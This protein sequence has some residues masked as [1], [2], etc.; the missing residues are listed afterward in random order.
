MKY[1][2]ALIILIVLTGCQQRTLNYA[3]IGSLQCE[4]DG[5]VGIKLVG[6]S[7]KCIESKNTIKRP[8]IIRRKT[9]VAPPKEYDFAHP[10]WINVEH[11]KKCETSI[12]QSYYDKKGKLTV[13]CRGTILKKGQKSKEITVRE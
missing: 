12:R 11:M 2:Y 4:S 6:N 8:K 5:N 13:T 1:I 9:V 7:Y 10:N 3:S